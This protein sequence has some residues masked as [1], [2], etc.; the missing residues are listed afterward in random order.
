M[1]KLKNALPE[2][3][4]TTDEID[5]VYDPATETLVSPYSNPLLDAIEQ[6]NAHRA[7][8]LSKATDE[9]IRKEYLT[10]FP[11]ATDDLL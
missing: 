8:E 6:D 2:G 4:D 10:R 11:E 3:F 9:E 7:W 5:L 1:S